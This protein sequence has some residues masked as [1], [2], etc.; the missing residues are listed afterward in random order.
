MAESAD[1]NHKVAAGAN[2]RANKPSIFNDA[3]LGGQSKPY[4]LGLFL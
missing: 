1:W 2:S 4:R 3:Q